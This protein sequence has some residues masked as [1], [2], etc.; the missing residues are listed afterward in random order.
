DIYAVLLL[1]LAISG[2]FMIKGRLGL[3][4][5]GAILISA[6]VSVPIAAVL[7]SGPDARRSQTAVVE[8]ASPPSPAPP[9]APP[10]PADNAPDGDSAKPVDDL[11]SD[12]RFLPPE[13]NSE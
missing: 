3:R 7:L 13:E 2:I 12:I 4:W 8:T 11:G 5:R 6:G 1:Y 9:P 10:A